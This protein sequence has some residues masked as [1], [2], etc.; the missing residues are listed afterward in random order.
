MCL[1]GIGGMYLYRMR[2]ADYNHVVQSGK[3]DGV[4]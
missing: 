2:L 3:W 4:A 1:A